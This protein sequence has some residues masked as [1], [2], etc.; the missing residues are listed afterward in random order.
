MFLQM[1]QFGPHPQ[2]SAIRL[3]VGCSSGLGPYLYGGVK[4]VAMAVFM[5]L[6]WL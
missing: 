1:R 6:L 3:V 2:F 5:L 4:L